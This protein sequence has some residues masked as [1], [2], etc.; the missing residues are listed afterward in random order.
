MSTIL[1]YGNGPG[2]WNTIQK[3]LQ[4]AANYNFASG[5]KMTLKG[6]VCGNVANASSVQ[7]NGNYS[8][9]GTVGGT[10][11]VG[12]TGPIH[13]TYNSQ[14]FDC[15]W[16][17]VLPPECPSPPN[18]PSN[19][20]FV[21]IAT[22]SNTAKAL[23][24]TQT[25]AGIDTNSGNVTIN[26]VSGL[27]VI[28]VPPDP[29]GTT[30]GKLQ[31]RGSGNL[32]INGPTDAVVIF[33]AGADNE[34]NAVRNGMD[35]QNGRSI[36]NTGGVQAQNILFNVIGGDIT[37]NAGDVYGNILVRAGSDV[38]GKATIQATSFIHG[39][40]IGDGVHSS[41]FLLDTDAQICGAFTS[42]AVKKEV[43]NNNGVT[44][45]DANTPP[46]PNIVNGTNPQFR[47]TA[48]NTST[49]TLTNVQVTDDVYGF[50][51]SV[52]S[53]S[54][55]GFA[56]W[57]ITKPW[58]VG[59]QVN[60]ATAT[61]T[62]QGQTLTATD[63]AYWLGV[64]EPT[65]AIAVLKEVSP[66]N[67][68]TWF[69]ANTPPGP[70]VPA[71]INPQFR[72]TV[73]NTGSVILTN[74]QVTDDVYGS[75][76]SVPS[77]AV[78]ASDQWIITRP[79]ADGQ[80]VNT[81]TATG[82]YQGQTLTATDPANWFGLA[83]PL[84]DIV[85]EVSPDNGATWFDANDPPGPDV[86]IG[87][88]P[89]FRFTVTNIGDVTLTNVQVT[90][91]VYGFI[92]SVPSLA[93][94]AFQQFTHTG[95]WAN[96]QH[97]NTATAT[98]VYNGQTLTITDSAYWFGA[99]PSITV[100]KE[101]SPD[102]G[103]T[104][105]DANTPPGPDVLFGT[106]PLFRFTVTNSGNV[107]LT[108]VQVTDDV[109]GF[110][111]SVPSLIPGAFEQFTHT[112]IWE[113]DQQV[114]TAT[115]TGQYDGLTLIDTDPA[116]WYGVQPAI[117]V[118]KEVSNDNG[119]TWFDANTP[120]GPYVVNGTQP[121]FRF[122]VTNTGNVTLSN[123]Q[124]N[125]DVYGFIGSVPS[126][127]PGSSTQFFHT[128]VWLLGQQVNTAT[129]TGDYLGQTVTDTDPAYWFGVEEPTPA[130]A[131]V[132]EVS[133]DNGVTWIDANTPPGPDVVVGINPQFRF[134][135]T[136]T[137]SVTLS[138]VQVTDDVYGFIGS[139]PSLAP[140]ASAQ[141]FHTGVWAIGQHVNI[142]TATGDYL[143]QTVTATDQAYWFGAQPGIDVRKEVSPDNGATWF[144]ANTPPGPD[145][146]FGTNPQFRF[147]VTNTGNVALLSVYV[148]DD[149][150][151]FIGMVPS[152]APGASAQF[153]HTGVWELGQQMDTATANGNY[154]GQSFIATDPAHWFGVQPA[155]QVVKEV[156][157]DNGTTW[158]DANTPPGPNVVSPTNPQFRF[159]VTNTGNATLTNVQVTDDVYGLIGSVPSLI[160]GASSQFFHTGVW[161]LGQ[162]VNTAT[163]TGEYQGQTV[164]GNDSA[165]WFGEEAPAPAI[166]VD[167]LISVDGGLTYVPADAPPY[168]TLVAPMNPMYKFV[169]TNTGNVTLSLVSLSDS[170]FGSI[171]VGGT[172][173][174][175]AS[176]TVFRT[177]VFA[178]GQHCNTA[179]VTG[180][181]VTETGV[182]E[183][184]DSDS[185]C[186]VG[187]EAPSITIEKFVSVDN[188]AT[189]I[190]A[191]TPPGPLLPAG[192]T[193]QFKFVVTNTGAVT[194]TN[195]TV[196]DNVFGLIGNLASLDPSAS[197]EWIIS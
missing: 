57:A 94:G 67:G 73:S 14:P 132:K 56:Q 21:D 44:W 35:I 26:V 122:T 96:G 29:Y 7:G 22:A 38:K 151:G 165:Y 45:F 79:W 170:T 33:N 191:N 135:V 129:A 109:Y 10:Q 187:V 24:P 140:G 193:P 30:E 197:F 174:P 130:I 43:S 161:L 175:G 176:F 84:I 181:Y 93:P 52:P 16:W 150:Y 11:W 167:K 87:T 88:N 185:A 58:A 128:G 66:D 28:N 182:I 152:M 158:F 17:T 64:E 97:V 74:V 162:Q 163:A 78:G 131:V 110:I 40:V 173:A 68:V 192:V 69:D 61:G 51:G 95:V 63:P 70:N 124:V 195:I 62:Y 86:L 102:N 90:D 71:S 188:G 125:D 41:E 115:A 72:F 15:Q 154:N 118:V 113:L 37:I 171:T 160:P 146:I 101:V 89:I 148:S 105:F 153:T 103:A 137:G 141:F 46:G 166:R 178:V 177:G 32:I 65:P 9:T 139:V 25:Y 143:G 116:Y 169:V 20:L 147:T 186:Y 75:I 196:T 6:T 81:A 49:V 39:I 34:V 184:D 190:H 50:I 111:G 126:L 83:S 108:N 194:L 133:P 134:T 120:P 53:L 106:N 59:Q 99:E 76:G 54:P 112:G 12:A 2:E 80:H 156:S 82:I 117:Q 183:V 23:T 136:N 8:L 100:V 60:T 91:D 145:V 155:I 123:V 121:Q 27:N 189:W 3:L 159:T 13:S 1:S 179:T 47:F 119:T 77:L 85:K 104:W 48:T 149:V 127:S 114:N 18:E 138:N 107:T 144:D 142:A 42:I 31:V 164:I 4:T 19:Q 5:Q 92:G 180:D 168:P 98:G 157:N 36:L 55:S 172:L